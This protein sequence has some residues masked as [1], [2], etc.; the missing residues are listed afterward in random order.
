M[1]ALTVNPRKKT[2]V[3][4][5]SS[6]LLGDERDRHWQTTYEED[7]AAVEDQALETDQM[8]EMITNWNYLEPHQREVEYKRAL[9]F[10][11]EEGRKNC[12]LAV[13][14]KITQRATGGAFAIR[15]A[16]KLFDRDG[17]GDIDPDEFKLA[18]LSFGLTFTDRQVLALFGS[19]DDNCSGALDYYEFLDKVLESDYKNEDGS[20]VTSCR[21]RTP[22]RRHY[23]EELDL[24]RQMVR[25]KEMYQYCVAHDSNRIGVCEAR[26]FL[27]E[28]GHKEPDDDNILQ[29]CQAVC[30]A[31][32]GGLDFTEIWDWFVG[33]KIVPVLDLSPQMK[34]HRESHGEHHRDGEGRR[35]DTLKKHFHMADMDIDGDGQVSA[36]EMQKWRRERAADVDKDGTTTQEELDAHHAK[37]DAD[38]Q[39]SHSMLQEN[40]KVAPQ[41]S[42]GAGHMVAR[43]LRG[44]E[45]VQGPFK[46]K[47]PA[48]QI[49][50]LQNRP[51]AT[52]TVKPRPPEARPQTA[53]PNISSR[54][55]SDASSRPQTAKQRVGAFQRTAPVR[56]QTARTGSSTF[57]C[58]DGRSN[59]STPRNSV[60]V[61]ELF[62]QAWVVGPKSAKVGCSSGFK[63]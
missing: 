4:N 29:I 6:L 15:K 19:Y 46:A 30:P 17:S 32:N 50:K 44:N 8:D 20:K 16:F 1:Y 12:E 55:G 58:Y 14:D 3:K 43:S 57:R 49:S 28:C 25:M 48:I 41:A 39:K 27:I 26:D 37:L 63:V 7:T 31:T 35:H 13:R 38:L 18:M 34:I 2:N 33:S 51:G 60:K 11:T 52:P 62:K 10:V 42:A 5:R 56:P 59:A 9:H 36:E 61:P 54:R 40:K 53:R 21:P 22:P 45:E 24:Y 23:V 47:I